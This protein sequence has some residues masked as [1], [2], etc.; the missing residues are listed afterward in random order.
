MV[1]NAVWRNLDDFEGR[2][3]DVVWRERWDRPIFYEEWITIEIHRSRVE[4]VGC[5]HVPIESR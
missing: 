4:S 3:G 1:A 2:I 5:E